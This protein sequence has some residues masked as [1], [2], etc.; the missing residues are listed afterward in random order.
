MERLSVVCQARGKGSLMHI[1][2]RL[3]VVLGVSVGLLGMMGH[4][5]RADE[6]RLKDGTKLSGTVLH[7]DASGVVVQLPRATVEAV[8]DQ[9]LPPPVAVGTEAP[10]FTAV[11]VQG[12]TQTFSKPSGQ[13]TLLAFWATWCPHCRSDVPLL[14]ELFTKYHPQGLRILAVSV[15]RDADAV[16]KFLGDQGVGYTVIT[17]SAQPDVAKRS[18]PDAYEVQGIPA[19]YLVDAQG[20]IARTKS[21]SIMEGKTQSEWEEAVKGLLPKPAPAARNARKRP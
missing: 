21:G 9:L 2:R 4:P 3:W 18:I 10:E 8:N 15:D 14:Q 5:A 17:A 16:K 13:P 7:R 19:Y 20:V 6:I 11:D 1:V 12:A